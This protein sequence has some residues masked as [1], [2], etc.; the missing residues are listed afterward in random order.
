MKELYVKPLSNAST[1][2]FPE[3]TTHSFK[4]RLPYRIHLRE[5][6]WKVGLVNMA[7]PPCR[8]RLPT[9]D[10]FLFRFEW[11]IL[12]DPQNM[13]ATEVGLIR[14]A[15]I[16]YPCKTGTEL[17]TMVSNKYQWMMRNQTVSD[18]RFTEKGTNHKLYSTFRR[19]DEGVFELNNEGVVLSTPAIFPKVAIG[20]HLALAMGWIRLGKLQNLQPGCVLGF[21]L[22]K[23]FLDDRVLE[24]TDLIQAQNNGDEIFY[25][26][27]HDVLK[28]SCFCNWRFTNMDEAF[29]AAFG[30]KHNTLYMYSNVGQSQVTGHHVTDLLREV[31]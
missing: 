12:A 7:L 23:E 27:D 3:N 18:L 24:A 28:L 21:N 11:N 2:E 1:Q 8:P 16:S 9:D 4:N 5:P 15:D 30:V 14:A 20:K 25:V 29:T 31:P 26:I 17:L 19:L 10:T 22:R 6:G 13:Y